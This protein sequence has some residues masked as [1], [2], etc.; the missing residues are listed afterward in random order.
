RIYVIRIGMILLALFF[1]TVLLFNERASEH[2]FILGALIGIGYGCYWMSFKLLTF[3]ITELETRD[4]FNGCLGGLESITGIVGLSLSCYLISRFTGLT[5]YSVIFAISF[6]LFL[7]AIVLSFFI[8]QRNI[9][10]QF[11][12][13]YV[14]DEKKENPDWS[15]LLQT[16][17]FEG[18]RDGV[19]LFVISIWIF[20]IIDSELRYGV[21]N[22]VVSLLALISYLVVLRII[23]ASRRPT[24]I[25]IGSTLIYVAVIFILL[26]E[27]FAGQLMVYAVILG[28]AEPIF[29]VAYASF[30]YDVIGKSSEAGPYRVEYIVLRELYVSVG[31]IV[32]VLIFLAGIFVFPNEY[33]IT[34]LILIFGCSYI[35][36]YFVIKKTQVT[37]KL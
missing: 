29:Y 19:F 11:N 34:I 13:K 1:L 30:T 7:I 37:N 23:R 12:L 21:I 20:M 18:L 33:V 5:G 26:P 4:V 16:H 14:I 25:L 24:F 6:F 27:L 15:L 8:S 36:M 3:E 10:G 32:S 22:T 35:W 31:R 17:F 28:I 2:I 9:R